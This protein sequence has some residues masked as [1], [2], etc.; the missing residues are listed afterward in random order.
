MAEELA[1]VRSDAQADDWFAAILARIRFGTAMAAMIKMIATTIN[2]S[3]NEK[4]FFLLAI[5]ATVPKGCKGGSLQ[6]PPLVSRI[7]Y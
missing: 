5:R 2:N 7:Y 4:P 3:I 1:K 6:L